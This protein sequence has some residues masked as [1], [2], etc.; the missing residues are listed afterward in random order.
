M[1]QGVARKIQSATAVRLSQT[2]GRTP[3]QKGN[4][5]VK[6][7]LEIAAENAIHRLQEMEHFHE[8]NNQQWIDDLLAG[9]AAQQSEATDPVVRDWNTPEEDAA[10]TGL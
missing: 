8:W 4:S 10:W 5:M 3:R 1:I 7:L 2:I 9:I 6:S